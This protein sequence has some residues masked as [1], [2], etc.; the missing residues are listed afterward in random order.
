MTI[1][2]NVRRVAAVV[3]VGTVVALAVPLAS[4]ARAADNGAWSAAPT[5]NGPFTPR[6]FFFF[7]M[8]PG[9][10]IKDSI[11]IKNASDQPLNLDVFPADAFNT[12]VGAGFALRKLGE[13]NT[14]VGSWITL[15]KK[16]VTLAPGAETKVP[17]TMTTPRGTTPGDHAGGI[18]TIEPPPTPIGGDSQVVT[19]RALGVRIYV[20]V[21]GP[22]TP[23]LTV[24]K[25]D[26]NVKPARLPFIGQQGG[27]T[28]TYTVANTGNVR[29]TADRVITIKGL[30]GRTV[31]D[32]GKGPIPEI[33]P[34]STV[35]LTESFTKMPVLNQVTARVQLSEDVT[36]VSSAGDAT[37]WSVSWVFLF[38]LI[39]LIVAVGVAI[40]WSRRD[41]SKVKTRTNAANPS[42]PP[43]EQVGNA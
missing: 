35:I 37:A 14:D 11:T 36:K 20:R 27:A 24:Q 5:K 10:T 8:A 19:R 2:T 32:T 13:K 34:G 29:I 40:W 31:H 15:G 21:A 39:L 38:L 26:L 18:V 43:V 4:P 25:V 1:G 23:S 33:L 16:K 17:F 41:P 28:V 30:L 3:A 6:Q 12:V 22:L 9:Q 7:E 42:D